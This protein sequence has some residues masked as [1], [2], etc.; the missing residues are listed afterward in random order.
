VRALIKY[1]QNKLDE[2][3]WGMDGTTRGMIYETIR[4]LKEAEKLSNLKQ[5]EWQAEAIR[6]AKQNSLTGDRK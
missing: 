5:V 6:L 3:R 1:W 4:A 2:C